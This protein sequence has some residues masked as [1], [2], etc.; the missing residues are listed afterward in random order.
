MIN[1]TP[2]H[3]KAIKNE[4]EKQNTRKQALVEL[5]NRLNHEN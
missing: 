4:S 1:P 5:Y 3:Q 2:Q